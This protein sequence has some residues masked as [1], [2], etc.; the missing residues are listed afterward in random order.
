MFEGLNKRSKENDFEYECSKKK[1]KETG[2]TDHSV[3][4]NIR[5]KEKA[6]EDEIEKRDKS[7]EKLRRQ[8]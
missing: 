7:S 2:L 8:P 5:R 1:S 4:R 6:A 3:E